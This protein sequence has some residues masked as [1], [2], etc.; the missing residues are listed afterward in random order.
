MA[1]ICTIFRYIEKEAQKPNIIFTDILR[2]RDI[3]I[4][5]LQLLETRSMTVKKCVLTYNLLFSDLRK[6]RL[7]IHWN[8]EPTAKFNPRSAVQTFL[9][10]KDRR[11]NLPKI[12]SRCEIDFFKKFFA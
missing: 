4:Q 8:E 2:H 10:T 7:I 9:T 3:A 11:M 6:A 12:D 1:D 5:K